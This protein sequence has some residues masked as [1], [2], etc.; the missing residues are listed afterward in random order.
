M[1]KRV[2]SLD[3]PIYSIID[4][5]IYTGELLYSIKV[6]PN[7]TPSKYLII[8]RTALMAICNA[9]EAN[10][11][12]L[13]AYEKWFE[14]VRFGPPPVIG[15]TNSYKKMLNTGPVEFP[16]VYTYLNRIRS[17]NP[18]KG[19]YFGKKLIQTIETNTGIYSFDFDVGFNDEADL[20]R[21]IVFFR[22]WLKIYQS[23]DQQIARTDY[24]ILDFIV[25]R[26]SRSE[27]E[28]FEI[29]KA[30]DIYE[31]FNF[32]C[33]SAKSALGLLSHLFGK[34]HIMVLMCQTTAD[35]TD[36]VSVLIIWKN[37]SG[38]S[39]FVLD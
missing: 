35:I 28:N 25:G 34:H 16:D 20:D 8:D 30:L 1:K 39:S 9:S 37:R 26:N 17:K 5:H 10:R 11:K 27:G 29:S 36:S 33:T 19:Y 3:R 7:D 14:C 22:A 18:K 15:V 21:K 6:R 12:L 24:R 32:R 4:Q 13:K 38:M 2:I 23:W 31:S